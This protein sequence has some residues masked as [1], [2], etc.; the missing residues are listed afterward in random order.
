[1]QENNIHKCL[2]SFGFFPMTLILKELE[3]EDRFEECISILN[4]MNTYRKKFNI[5]EDD[6]PTKW[7]ESFEKEYYSYF[8]KLDINGELLAKSNMEY[9][10][11]EIKKRLWRK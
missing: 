4:A 8:S 2:I 3:S 10:L 5:V 6:I 7:S 11:K 9:Y 1:M